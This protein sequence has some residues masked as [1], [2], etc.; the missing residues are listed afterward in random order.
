MQPALTPR[1]YPSLGKSTLL[2]V[3]AGV[4]APGS[5][6]RSQGETV[7]LAYFAQHPPDVPADL[8]MID[9]IREF[10]QQDRPKGI[11]VVAAAERAAIAKQAEAKLAAPIAASLGNSEDSPPCFS[12][13]PPQ[14]ADPSTLPNASLCSRSEQR[15][16]R[17]R[18]RGQRCRG[19][20]CGCDDP[21]EGAGKGRLP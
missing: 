9:Y 5:G 3:I 16:Q 2:D 6:E 8:K 11:D 21:G 12:L 15:G 14:I 10:V 17:G 19:L 13:P 20:V 1:I 7:R 4:T 18:R